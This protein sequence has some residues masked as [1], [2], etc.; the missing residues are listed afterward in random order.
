MHDTSYGT[1]AYIG[2]NAAHRSFRV[3]V[4]NAKALAF[5]VAVEEPNVLR[6]LLAQAT[7]AKKMPGNG[8]YAIGVAGAVTSNTLQGGIHLTGNEIDLVSG[9]P[10]GFR[11]QALGL[12]Y[13][14]I[15]RVFESFL[16]D[17]FGEIATR[18]RRVLFSSQ[19]ITYEEALRAG[20]AAGI[21]AVVLDRR[22]TDLTRAG[23]VGLEKAYAEIGL[24]IV[25]SEN[26]D[27]RG[28]WSQWVPFALAASEWTAD[29]L[30]ER[31]IAKYG[32]A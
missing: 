18:E 19:T 29:H 3:G 4:T 21:L 1:V 20:D 8:A 15:Y 25:D 5:A 32:I 13:R 14:E 10:G 9:E 22:K 23:F 24:P 16:V 17:L 26:A 12:I 27:A 11:S 28:A 7:Q 31:A 2:P 6:D 30:N